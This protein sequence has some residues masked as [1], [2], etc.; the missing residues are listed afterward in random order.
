MRPQGRERPDR[1]QTS[2]EGQASWIRVAVEFDRED[3]ANIL[4]PIICRLDRN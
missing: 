1:R 4:G 2:S 3:C